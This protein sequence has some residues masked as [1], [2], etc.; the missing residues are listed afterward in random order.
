MKAG[1]VAQIRRE[2]PHVITQG[3]HRHSRWPVLVA[4]HATPLAADEIYAFVGHGYLTPG[5]GL[6]Q[7]GRDAILDEMAAKARASKGRYCIVW[8]ADDCTFLHPNGEVRHGTIPPRGDLRVADAN[9]QTPIQLED[10]HHIELPPGDGGP[11]SRHLCV[12]RDGRYVQISL[13]DPMAIADFCDYEPD[14]KLAARCRDAAGNWKLPFVWRGVSVTA[15]DCD[16]RIL[17]G[18][19][20]PQGESG[21]IV[22]LD[23][24]PED[25]EAACR[26]IAASPIPRNVIDRA[27][28]AINPTDPTMLEVGVLAA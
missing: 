15:T 5:G 1:H 13:G 20:Q 14:P 6:T 19:I 3:P 21:T 26:K 17:L 27:W 7:L 22:L 8:A 12:K 18:P 16:G 25:F 24:W 11:F 28:K 4:N 23:P 9:D 2:Y 10:V